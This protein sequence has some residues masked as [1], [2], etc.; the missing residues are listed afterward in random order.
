MWWDPGHPRPLLLENKASPNDA[1]GTCSDHVRWQTS[2]ALPESRQ[3]RTTSSL[4]NDTVRL[5]AAT[6]LS[7][8]LRLVDPVCRSDTRGLAL[9]TSPPA[10]SIHSNL[11]G[12]HSNNRPDIVTVC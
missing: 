10:R 8:N 5:M 4:R 2:R 9:S 12:H 11:V 3:Q 1:Q 6:A 7:Q